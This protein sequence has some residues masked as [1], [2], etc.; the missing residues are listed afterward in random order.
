M[1]SYIQFIKE[2][3]ERI[4]SA[5]RANHARELRTVDAGLNR[6]L[7]GID[8]FARV[9]DE[10]DN[11]LEAAS[12]FLAVRSFNSLWVARQALEKGY[13]QQTF[14]LVRMAMEDQL[15]ARDSENYPATLDALFEGK[16]R[17]TRGKFA[18]KEM[19]GRLPPEEGE[20]W[21]GQ[22]LEVSAYASHP[23][24]DSMRGVTSVEPS[25][26]KVLRPGGHEYDRLAIDD[27]IYHLL[28]EIIDVLANLAKVLW[29]IDSEWVVDTVPVREQLTSVR[30]KLAK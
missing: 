11:A 3:E 14:S 2:T 7:H 4:A 27:A 23:A 29:G 20:G 17:I 15:V 28:T 1:N 22:Y 30:N 13:Y 26:R 5:I 18:F 6:V 16:G 12:L 9:K 21:L 8:D 25:G 24:P 19:A 10:P